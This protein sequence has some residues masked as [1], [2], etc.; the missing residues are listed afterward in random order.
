MA[1][2][3]FRLRSAQS[4]ID[5]HTSGKWVAVARRRQGNNSGSSFSHGNSCSGDSSVV[6]NFS[7]HFLCASVRVQTLQRSLRNV[8][9]A[10][11][12]RLLVSFPM[13]LRDREIHLPFENID[14]GHKN[15]QLVADAKPFTRPSANELTSSRLKQ[16]E[17]VRERGHMDKAG[18]KRIRQFHHQPVIADIDN[19]RGKI[20][21]LR[22]SSCRWKNSSFF[23]CVA[24]I[25][26]S[27]AFRSVVERCS[28]IEAI[29]A[30]PRTVSWSEPDGRR[31]V[32]SLP[33]ARCTTRSA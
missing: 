27:A 30:M 17:V 5:Q 22:W 31:R 25:S 23:I 9:D 26:A 33:S 6:A 8:S 19:C 16:I 12:R 2:I 11:W 13:A 29:S 3:L 20:C 28:A 24:S 32:P 10:A 7:R 15:R 18:D 1:R 21:G 14:S 4:A